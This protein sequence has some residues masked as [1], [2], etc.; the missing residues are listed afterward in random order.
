M[1]SLTAK[2][3]LLISC[4]NMKKTQHKLSLLGLERKKIGNGLIVSENSSKGSKSML[5]M[6]KKLNS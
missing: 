3:G 1:N 5:M 6:N 4:I 2:K